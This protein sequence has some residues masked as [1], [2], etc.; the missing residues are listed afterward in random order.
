MNAAMTSVE[1][2]W[3]LKDPQKNVPLLLHSDNE[4]LCMQKETGAWGV[5]LTFV[6]QIFVVTRTTTIPYF[7]T[8][9]QL[10]Q[11]LKKEEI[12]QK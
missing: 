2:Q 5:N 3:C 9:Q 6:K 7:L 11:D 4:L 8:E 10:F 1:V 12:Y